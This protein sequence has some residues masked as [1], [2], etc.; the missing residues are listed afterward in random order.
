MILFD[1]VFSL[2]TSNGGV[3]LKTTAFQVYSRNGDKRLK[4]DGSAWR[5]VRP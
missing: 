1:M 5:K 3:S 2:L 4:F